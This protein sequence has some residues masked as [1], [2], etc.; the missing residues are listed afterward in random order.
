MQDT[1]VGIEAEVLAELFSAFQQGDNSTTRKYGGTGLGLVITRQLAQLMGGDAGAES[2][3]GAGSMFWFTARLQKVAPESPPP[4]HRI[5]TPAPMRPTE[6]ALRGAI[7][8]VEDEPI[9]REIASG[10]TSIRAS[11]P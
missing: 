5:G 2:R 8:L 7:L 4:G 6:A 11:I 1:G 10:A 3:A 9:N